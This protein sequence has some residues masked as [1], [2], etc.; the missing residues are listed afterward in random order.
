MDTAGLV[1]EKFQGFSLRFH[2]NLPGYIF[3]S[4]FHL[5]FFNMFI[6][7]LVNPRID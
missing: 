5:H 3:G 4:H 1:C 2:V 6:D 7:G